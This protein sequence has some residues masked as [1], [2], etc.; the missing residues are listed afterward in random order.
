MLSSLKLKTILKYFNSYQVFQLNLSKKLLNKTLICIIS[1]GNPFLEHDPLFS[2]FHFTLNILAPGQIKQA[3]SI[4][5]HTS[6]EFKAVRLPGLRNF[7]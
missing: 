2:K 3:F 4:N 7:V 1:N 5:F 6:I